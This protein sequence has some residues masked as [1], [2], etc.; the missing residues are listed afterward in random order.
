M[1]TVQRFL[2][3][4]RNHFL[5]FVTLNLRFEMEIVVDVF[6]ADPHKWFVAQLAFCAFK[7]QLQA[8]QGP[9]IFIQKNIVAAV[10]F[11]DDVLD[12]ELVK[13]SPPSCVSP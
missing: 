5:V 6:F 8:P 11:V 4:R 2:Q 3:V 13:S 10:K 7:D 9:R 1:D 12:E